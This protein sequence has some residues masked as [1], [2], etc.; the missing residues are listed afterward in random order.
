MKQHIRHVRLE[1]WTKTHMRAFFHQLKRATFIQ[2]ITL[3]TLMPRPRVSEAAKA[4][5]PFVKSL[6]DA[7]DGDKAEDDVLKVIRTAPIAFICADESLKKAE[8][9]RAEEHSAAIRAEL[10]KLLA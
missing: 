3:G 7:Q 6:K 9:L 5:K 4:L 10:K 2:T 1:T 8:V